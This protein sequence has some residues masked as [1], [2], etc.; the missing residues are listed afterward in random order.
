M[1]NLEENFI[2]MKNNNVNINL[3]KYAFKVLTSEFL[4]FM[5]I[6]RGIKVN[7]TNFKAIIEM[8]S[9]TSMKEVQRLN[10]RIMALS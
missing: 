6:E 2:V 3:T 1:A 10:G 7:T 9:P 4:G 5:V 8:R